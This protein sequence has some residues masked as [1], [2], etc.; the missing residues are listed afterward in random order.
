MTEL[1]K[2]ARVAKLAKEK[3][4]RGEVV[5]LA[6]ARAATADSDQ[7]ILLEQSLKDLLDRFDGLEAEKE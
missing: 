4:V 5:R 1:L 3:S 2:S 7:S 6:L